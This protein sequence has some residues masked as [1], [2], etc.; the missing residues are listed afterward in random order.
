MTFIEKHIQL[1]SK[2]HITFKDKKYIYQAYTIRASKTSLNK[3]KKIKLHKIFKYLEAKSHTKI[4][5]VSKMK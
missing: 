5:H 1:Y 4:G 3:L 2:I